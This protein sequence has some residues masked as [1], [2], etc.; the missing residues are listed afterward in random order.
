MTAGRALLIILVA[1]V[2]TFATRLF[3]F[4]V[5]GGK[6][7]PSPAVRF[8]GSC[9]PSAIIAALVVYCLRGI[10]LE[11][12]EWLNTGIQLFS[13]MIVAGLHL[14]KKNILLSIGGGTVCYML[15]LRTVPAL[16]T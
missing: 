4:V 15:L 12:S 5:F 7:E 8:L 11:P 16:L 3:P 10:S 1:A 14:W 2:C 13:V 9:L 6:K